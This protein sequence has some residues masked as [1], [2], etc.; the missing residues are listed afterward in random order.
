MRLGSFLE[1]AYEQRFK[2]GNELEAWAKSAARRC[3]PEKA[4]KD[5]IN[6]AFSTRASQLDAYRLIFETPLE[7]MPAYLEEDIFTAIATWRLV[8][9]H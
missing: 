5:L 3:T 6:I 2:D 8:L 1:G 4:L 7:D 9:G